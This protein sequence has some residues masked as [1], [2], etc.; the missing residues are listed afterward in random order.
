VPTTGV[1]V[2]AGLGEDTG[3]ASVAWWSIR[4][5]TGHLPYDDEVGD[6]NESFFPPGL[7]S[8]PPIDSRDQVVIH[9]TTM[10]GGAHV[11]HQQMWPLRG[12]AREDDGALLADSGIVGSGTF[13]RAGTRVW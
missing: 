5:G 12:V 6:G 10:R 2:A 1:G 13:G 3:G 9:W 8:L 4:E 11:C 7:T